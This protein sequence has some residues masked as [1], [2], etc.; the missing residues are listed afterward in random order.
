MGDETGRILIGWA[1]TSI[2]PEEP[3]QVAGQWYERISERVMDPITATALALE[4]VGPDG[5]SEQAI[6]VSCDLVAIRTGVQERVRRVVA[7]RLPGF[8]VRKVF[9]FATHTHTGPALVEG[10]WYPDPGP[11]VMR[12]A[13]YVELLAERVGDAVARAWESREP[14]GVSWALDYA[15]L[16]GNRRAVYLDGHAEMYGRTD[17]DDFA[18]L[19][20]SQ[21]HGVE[22]LF[23]WSQDQELTGLVVNVCATPQTRAHERAISADAWTEM[24]AEL[25]RRNSPDLFVLPQVS[26]AGDQCPVD[27]PRRFR[28]FTAQGM[29]R[30]LAGAVE[31][32]L[33]TA[34]GDIRSEIVFKHRV[35]DLALPAR[36]VT[37]EEAERARSTIA[38]LAQRHPT[39]GSGE[40]GHLRAQQIVLQRY[41]QQTP[42]LEYNMELHVLRLGDIAMATNPFELYLDYGYRIKARSRA[43]QTFVVQLSCD[44][45]LY[46][47][48]VRAVA[49]G[50]YSATVQSNLVGPE[51]GRVLVDE[52][53]R[54][55]NE[56]WANDIEEG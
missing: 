13:E 22:M 41:Q 36:L 48:T 56:M 27:L 8:D 49:G 2:T 53:V 29:A 50:S 24:R 19:E 30:R 3:V 4:T 6:M 42:D 55:I 43:T 52:T 33:P 7:E 15:V 10:R 37:D 12:A 35:T 25:R 1:S 54:A 38:E 9:L 14:G 26:A 32:A 40:Y 28:R 18:G 5:S 45:G 31:R 44:S 46:L 34:R 16:G 23:T 39:P 20:G 11:G 17:G 47:P 21:D 51:G